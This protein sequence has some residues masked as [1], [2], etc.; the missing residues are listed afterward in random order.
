MEE[1]TLQLFNRRFDE[2]EASCREARQEVT[3]ARLVLGE[4]KEQLAHLE[5]QLEQLNLRV[6]GLIAEPGR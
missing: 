1:I 6:S 5:Q 2:A 4:M 3:R